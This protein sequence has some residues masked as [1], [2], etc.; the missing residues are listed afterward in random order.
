MDGVGVTQIPPEHLENVSLGLENFVL[1][2]RAIGTVKEKH[3][4]G[5]H[6]LLDFGSDKKGCNANQMKFSERYDLGRE[7]VIEDVDCK[8]KGFGHQAEVGVDLDEPVG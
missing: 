4:G 5:W 6:D 7:E 3:N 8:E 1:G 2:V